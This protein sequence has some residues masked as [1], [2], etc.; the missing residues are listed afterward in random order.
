MHRNMRNVALRQQCGARFAKC[1]FVDRP[2]RNAD[3]ASMNHAAAS[4][5]KGAQPL[6]P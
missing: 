5:W 1:A 4:A 6:N 3:R 2:T